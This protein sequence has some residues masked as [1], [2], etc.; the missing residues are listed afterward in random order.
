[1]GKHTDVSTVSIGDHC[2]PNCPRPAPR[3]PPHLAPDAPGRVEVGEDVLVVLDVG[4][5]GLGVHRHRVLPVLVQRLQVW[6]GMGWDC[7]R[8]GQV[9]PDARCT[10]QANDNVPGWCSSWTRSR[11]SRFRPWNM[12][13]WAV[14]SCA[15]VCGGWSESPPRRCWMD[16]QTD[17]QVLTQITHRPC[18]GSTSRCSWSRSAGSC[19]WCVCW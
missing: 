14:V 7:E 16:R 6:R 13:R 15:C 19:L 1:M 18:R 11:C 3:I 12:R 9:R 5:E 8:C 10:R 17:R 4:R 2:T